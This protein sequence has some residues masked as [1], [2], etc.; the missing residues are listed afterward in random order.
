MTKTTKFG[1][2]N[3]FNPP[4]SQ[5]SIYKKKKKKKLKELKKNKIKEDI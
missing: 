1:L 3:Y 2:Q 4:A 5:E